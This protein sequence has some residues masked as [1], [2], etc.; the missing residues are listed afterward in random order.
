[1]I[2]HLL[3]I[4]LTGVIV[5]VVANA[6]YLLMLSR[7][8]PKV[9]IS[10][11]I[12]K[13]EE[14]H[15]GMRF[16]VKVIN[17][18]RWPITDIKAQLHLVWNRQEAGGAIYRSKLIRLVQD[19]PIAIDKYSKKDTEAN[20]AYRFATQEPLDTIWVD[21]AQQFLRF[22]LI[23]KH[24]LSGFGGFFVQDFRVKRHAIRNGSF[25]KGDTCEIV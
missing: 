24:S 7:L 11:H 25:V 17:R 8:R 15:T 5:G 3:E 21:D 4:L 18:T 9:Q 20:Y 23:C 22:R 14:P 16:R 19:A 1:M 12:A 6:L 10:E 13:G 2:N